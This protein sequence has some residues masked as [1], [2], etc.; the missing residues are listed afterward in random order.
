MRITWALREIDVQGLGRPTP[1]HSETHPLASFF[2]EFNRTRVNREKMKLQKIRSLTLA[3]TLELLKPV[4][5]Q[6]PNL[7]RKY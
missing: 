6:C 2:L 7:K 3:V 1:K 4:G 5:T